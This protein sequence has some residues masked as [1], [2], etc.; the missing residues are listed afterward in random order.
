MEEGANEG[1]PL[2]ATQSALVL[3]K[4]LRP[5]DV[6]MEA[7]ARKRLLGV[8]VDSSD[9]GVGGETHLIGYIDD[10]GKAASH[11]DVLFFF[12]GFNCLE[13]SLGIFRNQSK[14]RILVSTNGICSLTNIER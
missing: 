3:G 10:V 1:C 13:Q 6:A 11:V 2:S 7:R 4:G 12:K 9:D 14:T 8:T 5:L